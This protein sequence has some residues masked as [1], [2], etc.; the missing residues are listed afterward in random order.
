MKL[1][2]PA[3]TSWPL[4]PSPSVARESAASNISSSDAR[5]RIASSPALL[6]ADQE[7][8]PLR[9]VAE[10]RVEPAVRHRDAAVEVEPLLLDAFVRADVTVRAVRDEMVRRAVEEAARHAERHEDVLGDVDLVVVAGEQLD[11]AAEK[12]DARIRVAILR[13]RLEEQLRVRKHRHD[14][15][16][17]R[18]LERMPRLVAAPRPRA[19]AEAAAVRHQVTDGHLRHVAERVVDLRAA[20]ART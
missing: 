9:H 4:P 18:R 13:A 14:L 12:D 19:G 17:A 7:R 11:D 6:A 1:E 20:P 15:L 8:Q 2:S 5:F 10:R 16:P 3:C